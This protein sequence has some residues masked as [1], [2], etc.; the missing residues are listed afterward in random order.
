M[1]MI[2]RCFRSPDRRGRRVAPGIGRDRYGLFVE[3]EVKGVLFVLR[4]ILPG[5]FMIGSPPDEPERFDNEDPQHRGRFAQDF[6]LA[7]TACTQAL[8]RAVMG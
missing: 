3:V 5:E 4:W 7:E 1:M 8:W 2:S 6:W